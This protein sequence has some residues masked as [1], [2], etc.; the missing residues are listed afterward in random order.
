M[1]SMKGFTLL[2]L[3]VVIVLVGLLAAIA[4][5]EYVSWRT[6]ARFNETSQAIASTLR[7]ARAQ[8]LS[9]NVQQR[10]EFDLA[11]RRYR[12]LGGDRAIN[13]TAFATVIKDWTV[14]SADTLL[15]GGGDCSV[16]TALNLDFNANGTAI[17][18]SI[19]ILASGPPVTGYYRVGVQSATTGRIAITRL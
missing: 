12:T 8:A 3:M 5:P 11:N 15:R 16:D 7:E 18:N 17:Q 14:L 4:L 13:S 9:S 1:A 2:E 19:C 10:V 6:R